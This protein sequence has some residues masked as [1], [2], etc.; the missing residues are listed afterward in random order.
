[1]HAC[2]HD[3]HTTILLTAARYLAETKNFNGTVH[4]IFQPAEEGYGGA[5]A[6][7]EDGLFEKFPCDAVYG[8]HNWPGKPAG[9]LY[10]GSGPMMASVD[11]AFITI[12][13]R[14]GHGAVPQNA[15]DPI[16]AA[17]SV[18]MALQ[19]IVSRNVSPL[20]QALVTVG[21][22]QGGSASN[23]IP[24]TVN[25]ELTI[26]AFSQQV[27]DLL[28]ERIH[29]LVHAQAASYGAHAK[30]NYVDGYP[31]LVNHA[32]E[33]AYAQKVAESQFGKDHVVGN[34][35]PVTPAEDFS[36][37]LQKCPGSYVFLGNGNSADLH[38]PRY[39]FNDD[40]IPVGG[41]L[42]GALVEDYLR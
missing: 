33:T 39:V 13:G 9:T 28:K 38:N 24:D 21:L 37:M 14:G 18:V 29:E 27:R 23:I 22:F 31:S 26:R 35:S 20:D 32:T 8:L 5:Q 15:I 11:T 42:W 10:F 30:I 7:I 25:L 4:L 3:G 6:M 16:V 19:T 1:M 2:G 40:I 36:Y 34:A 12:E 41:S 17:S